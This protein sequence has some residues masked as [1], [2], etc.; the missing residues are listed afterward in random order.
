MDI[1]DKK[2]TMRQV[3]GTMMT[4]MTMMKKTEKKRMETVT[5]EMRRRIRQR[6]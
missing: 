5:T 3:S 1:T 4:T 2:N 6:S